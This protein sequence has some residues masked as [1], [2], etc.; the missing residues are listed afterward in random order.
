MIRK[1]QGG[2]KLKVYSV[3]GFLT[4]ALTF[5]GWSGIERSQNGKRVSSARLMFA[6]RNKILEKS[7]LERPKSSAV[8]FS[9]SSF[10]TTWVG[11]DKLK[12]ILFISASETSPTLPRI[13]LRAWRLGI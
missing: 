6:Y 2:I 9:S 1:I 5:S 7:F 4:T 12:L 8:N 13:N 3:A 11:P 10:Q